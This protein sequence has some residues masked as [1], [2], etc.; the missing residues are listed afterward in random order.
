MK[1]GLTTTIV[2][3]TSSLCF[4]QTKGTTFG[5]QVKPIIP[6]NY[7][8]AGPQ[9]FSDS[10]VEIDL[11]PKLGFS[12]GAI[13]RQRLS[14]SIAIESGISSVRRNYMVNAKGL[15]S[16]TS[17]QTDFGFVGYQVPLQA[18]FYIQLSE[19]VFM[20]T[21]AGIGLD[22]YPSS[23]ET[24][25]ENAKLINLTLRQ[26]WI[27]YSLLAN[28]GFEYRTEEK[29]TF[30]IGGSFN[31]PFKPIAESNFSYNY[32][33]NKKTRINTLLNGNYITLDLRFFFPEKEDDAKKK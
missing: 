14:K 29:G 32:E 26:F 12:F 1:F 19:K 7:F 2:I 15:T 4:S 3:L 28:I 5:F 23:I 24:I 9:S 11:I 10:L 30:Y 22:M 13:V 33:G 8:N 20:N 17:D 6:V 27:N 25:G 16:N 21:T 18:L 31:R